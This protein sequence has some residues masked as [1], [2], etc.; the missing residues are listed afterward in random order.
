MK[1]NIL[2]KNGNELKVQ[3]N[4]SWEVFDKYIEKAFKST[5]GRYQIPGFRK[6]KVPRKM[7]EKAYGEGIFY[8]DALNELLPEIYEKSIEEL[9]FD[10]I[11][12]PDIDITELEPGKEIAFTATV[13][14]KPEIEIEGYK[15]IEVKKPE[16]E[17]TE[18]ALNEEIDRLRDLN[19]R[20]VEVT[21]RETKEGDTLLIDFEGF[22][23]DEPFEGGKAE[24]FELVLGSSTFIPGF[25]DQL[26]GKN[27]GDEVTVNVTFP[28]D[29]SAEELAGKET[30]FEV[31]IHEVK[32]KELPELDDEFALDTSEYETLEELKN[33]TK[34]KLYEANVKSA[35]S[36]VR[37][38]VVELAAEKVDAEIPEVMIDN[39]VE[40]MVRDFEMQLS[41]QGLSLDQYNEYMGGSLDSLKTEM[42]DE[43][44][45]RVLTS[46][47]IE[48]ISEL[49]AVEVS[50]EDLDAEI[51]K[52]VESTKTSEE[53]AR[54]I[55][56]ADGFSYLKH[57]LKTR[58]TIDLLVENVK[59]ID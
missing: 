35:D 57:I 55:Y 45:K 50:E 40:T 26:I 31:K 28:E 10:P 25:E 3:Y 53:E 21:D 19:A 11:S 48:K 44:K 47:A 17:V 38:R 5:K 22:L 37:D 29:Y 41:Y 13:T 33:A 12:R 49:E 4:V 9:A 32:A 58:K 43:A 34:E 2:E 7:I 51:A 1:Y 8:D 14:V 18:E 42:R 59:F 39:E 20:I 15:G 24:G 6:G 56:G 30:R 23:G 46:L 54:K 16:T 27:T 52:I 36:F